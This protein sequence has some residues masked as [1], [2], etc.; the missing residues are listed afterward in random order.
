MDPPIQTGG[1]I[2]T[3]LSGTVVTLTRM[4]QL[5]V[6]KE[7]EKE[8]RS[9]VEKRIGVNLHPAHELTKVTPKVTTK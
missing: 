7:V 3:I 1:I 2:L 4:K 8:T 6:A 9:Q 5:K